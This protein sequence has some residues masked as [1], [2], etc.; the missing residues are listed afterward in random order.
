M[1]W[2]DQRIGKT[3]HIDDTLDPVWDLEIF[4]VKVDNDG[5][6][7]IEQSTLRIV[8]LDWDQFGSDDVL[9]QIEL[10]GWQIQQM[11]ESKDG[12]DVD[13][14]EGAMGE[15]EMEKVFDFLR[16]L[17]EHETGE[18]G[19]GKMVVGV[20]QDPNILKEQNQQ[21]VSQEVEVDPAPPKKKRQKKRKHGGTAEAG[22][23]QRDDH[24]NGGN[25][26]EKE[27]S[28]NHQ[29]KEQQD[30]TGSG[31][32]AA[33]SSK[34]E[35]QPAG[36]EAEP[37]VEV[38]PDPIQ[39][40]NAAAAVAVVDPAEHMEG[41]GRPRQEGDQGV[42]EREGQGGTPSTK[43]ESGPPFDQQRPSDNTMSPREDGEKDRAA[44]SALGEGQKSTAGDSTGGLVNAGSSKDGQ[45]S[46]LKLA[47]EREKVLGSSRDKDE[48]FTQD[49]VELNVELGDIEEGG[50][51]GITAQTTHNH[52][53]ASAAE[54]EAA[55]MV[56][57]QTPSSQAPRKVGET[58]EKLTTKEKL[59]QDATPPGAG[60][61]EGGPQPDRTSAPASPS[62][63]RKGKAKNR[64]SVAF[65]YRD[66]EGF[67]TLVF[68]A[69]CV[70]VCPYLSGS[71][72]CTMLKKIARASS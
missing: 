13:A 6:K 9:G 14:G 15:A 62:A 68:K 34:R 16:L 37:A 19:L 49:T 64:N 18:A 48:K 30:I 61:V 71:T 56:G 47:P 10:A 28:K 70:L 17:Q 57:D 50:A 1:Y 26:A 41:E 60:R 39:E 67:I 65:V 23:A 32:D 59:A 20:P 11:V 66:G 25:R 52:I 5:P 21:Q 38:H 43:E 35:V 3:V 40:S 8:C 36:G 46:L 72:R 27:E 54:T 55:D 2:N 44:A 63:K 22:S 45:A 12:D 24:G 58:L 31:V 42:G 51:Q 4:S 33:T 7:S 29:T 69:V 53:A